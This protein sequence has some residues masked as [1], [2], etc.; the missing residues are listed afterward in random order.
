MLHK[1]SIP[2]YEKNIRDT[3]TNEISMDKMTRKP[4]FYPMQKLRNKLFNTSTK[5]SKTREKASSTGN[6]S[7]QE[8]AKILHVILKQ[9]ILFF[10]DVKEPFSLSVAGFDDFHLD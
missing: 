10:R 9:Q 7:N 5:N 3:V 6:G 2:K 4:R 1:P 8:T